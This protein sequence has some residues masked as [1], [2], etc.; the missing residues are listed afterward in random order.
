MNAGV[1]DVVFNTEDVV[2]YLAAA[3]AGK[4]SALIDEME[5]LLETYRPDE[6]AFV[7]FTRKGVNVGLE[8]VLKAHPHLSP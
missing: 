3:G 4:T 8:R 6:I 2:V 7:T 5:K 1:T